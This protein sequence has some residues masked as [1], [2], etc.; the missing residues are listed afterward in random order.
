MKFLFD[1]LDTDCSGALS[2]NELSV[3]LTNMGIEI[4]D[5]EKHAL[6]KKLDDDADGEIGYDEFYR[7]LAEVNKFKQPHDLNASQILNIDHAMQKIAR[8]AE[9]YKCLEDY[10]ILLFKK[11]DVN[12]DGSISF[13]EMREGLNSLNVHLG[14]NEIHALFHHLDANRDSEIS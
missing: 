12:K 5:K 14:D 6:M 1:K 8:G 3:G 2:F 13:R 9:Q 11:F 10:I 7:G 4:T